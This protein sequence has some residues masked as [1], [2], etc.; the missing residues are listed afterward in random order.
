MTKTGFSFWILASILCT[1]TCLSIQSNYACLELSDEIE[2]VYCEAS[3]NKCLLKTGNSLYFFQNAPDSSTTACKFVE[4]NEVDI[5]KIMKGDD[6]IVP[7]ITSKYLV[8]CNASLCELFRYDF[9]TAEL[10]QLDSGFA[11]P[12]TLSMN[13]GFF[14]DEK[15]MRLFMADEINVS[16]EKA[17]EQALMLAQSFRSGSKAE[18]KML[19]NI[20]SH[21]DPIFTSSTIL[22]NFEFGDFFYVVR[23]V[24]WNE[25]N[26][27]TSSFPAERRKDQ[28]AVTIAR[29]CKSEKDWTSDT[30]P[31]ISYAEFELTCDA[32]DTG[33]DVKSAELVMDG[34]T[35]ELILLYSKNGASSK[36]CWFTIDDINRKFN[37]MT[38][39]CERS[40]FRLQKTHECE[41]VRCRLFLDTLNSCFNF[42]FSGRPSRHL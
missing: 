29:V 23:S 15:A 26:H 32:S 1:R 5:R 36:I 33:L 13:D 42:F 41:I 22:T 40:V 14:Y 27:A 20:P 34:K 17:D 8:I 6:W 2:A 9:N 31:F 28:K 10:T 37:Q 25:V 35:N 39:S 7:V 4:R 3:T 11:R 38:S 30:N 21:T 18:P 24:Q 12:T 19:L 16:G